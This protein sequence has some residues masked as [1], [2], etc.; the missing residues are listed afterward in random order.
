MEKLKTF[1][2]SIRNRFRFYILFSVI[3]TISLAAAVIFYV[4]NSISHDV[5]LN[6]AH[7]YTDSFV[8]EVESTVG[9]EILLTRRLVQTSTIIDWMKD[10]N[11]LE[12]KELAFNDLMQFN[13]L[14]HDN[15][16][17]LTPDRS[18]NFYLID[19]TTQFNN[20]TSL[21]TL[22]ESN[23]DDIWYY[24]AVKTTEPYQLNVDV[25]RYLNTMRVWI[26]M[27]VYDKDQSFIGVLGTG[28]YLDTLLQTIF[29]EHEDK[30]AKALIINEYGAIQLSSDP[31]QIMEN[32]FSQMMNVSK[33]IYEFVDTNTNK[34]L[35][36]T[37]LSQS[38]G[39]KIVELSGSKYQLLILSP[40]SETNWY[41]ATLYNN[42][43]LYD[44]NN[45]LPFIVLL[46]GV[47]L[48]FTI[49]L[50][51]IVN[52]LFMKPFSAL[53]KSIMAKEL[54][55]T[56]TLYGINRKDEF[57]TLSQSIQQMT[58]RMVQS[59]PVGMFLLSSKS[60][61]LYA[62]PYFLEQFECPS[63]KYMQDLLQKNF[64]AFFKHRI[65]YTDYIEQLSKGEDNYRFEFEVY[66]ATHISFWTEIYLTKTKLKNNQWQYEG[67]L[68]NIQQKK[69]YEQSL[70]TLA[71]TDRLTG[72]RNRLYFD[73]IVE[74]EMQRSDRYNHPIT[75]IMFD[76]DH[77]K[78][79]ND[80]YGHDIG[81]Q[82]LVHTANIVRSII[83]KTDILAR[84]GGEEIAILMPE[85]DKYGALI[86][87]EK[88][89]T[90]LESY[91]HEFVGIV[92]A[93]FGIAERYPLEPYLD[94]FKRVDQSVFE[95]KNNGRNAVTLANNPELLKQGVVRLVWQPTLNSGNHMID[96]EHIK[97]FTLTNNF[98][99]CAM[100][101]EDFEQQ[102]SLLEEI[103]H[104]LKE[105][106]RHEESVLKNVGYPQ[107]LLIVHQE[108]H[109]AI[110]GKTAELYSDF[111]E[112]KQIA[113][114]VFTSILNNIIVGHIIYEDTGFFSYL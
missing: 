88:I 41:V 64:S 47:I 15:N 31:T 58:D 27:K 82:V 104:H 66:T 32:S 87:A 12:L 93:S 84:W 29:S 33:T 24:E 90:A 62:N 109:T 21:G 22:E 69:D 83:R 99:E 43:N 101:K 103:L 52:Q 40:I 54:T 35:I 100:K 91:E 19:S 7:A 97:L 16:T 23:P 107:E 5:S 26:N 14:Y 34:E 39:T 61:L 51:V 78:N 105:H 3:L 59:V 57:G 56:S 11:N 28:I 113:T 18:K 80:L 68:I 106:F 111:K 92:T 67:I 98:L 46:L 102:I 65:D 89:R 77:F 53:N 42:K 94:W 76:L 2:Y 44:L 112:H 37:Y 9:R 108:K 36:K 75:M 73:L 38:S 60:E 10:E 114:E 70:V 45:L 25:D 71:S 95:S 85:T 6:Y 8:K 17:F 30:G 79:V 81:D 49:G 13:E 20:F 4:F 72:L 1:F 74:D 86:V 110:L 48:L 63:L 96:Q 55:H 50:N